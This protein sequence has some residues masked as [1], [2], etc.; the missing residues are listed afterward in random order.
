KERFPHHIRR[1]KFRT[2]SIQITDRFLKQVLPYFSFYPFEPEDSD[3]QKF[4]EINGKLREE[5]GRVFFDLRTETLPEPLWE[6]SWLRLRNAATMARFADHRRYYYKGEQVDEKVHMGVDLASL[7]NSEVP[8]A[9]SGR[10]IYRD[11]LGIYGNTVV[12]DHG[13]GIASVYA[14]LSDFS[15]DMGQEVAKGDVIGHTGQT[16]LAGGDH[17]HFGIMVGG[18]FVNPVEWWDSHWLRDNILR[19]LALLKP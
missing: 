17:L 10:V 3:I 1:K 15:V 8:A 13:Q 19:K 5:N 7:A 18:V 4:L 2:E 12:L 9:N 16:G 11:R 6:G 14:H